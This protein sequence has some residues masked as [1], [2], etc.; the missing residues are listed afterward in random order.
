MHNEV[1][2][3][4]FVLYDVHSVWIFINIHV[5]RLFILQLTSS[6]LLSRKLLVCYRRTVWFSAYYPKGRKQNYL[7]SKL[8]WLFWSRSLHNMKIGFL[9]SLPYT[10][11]LNHQNPARPVLSISWESKTLSD[12]SKW[13]KENW[14]WHFLACFQCSLLDN[15]ISI[16]EI[17]HS[18]LTWTWPEMLLRVH[19]SL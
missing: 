7:F 12:I 19:V 13:K 9:G 17:V 11:V 18:Q 14:S 1:L 6:I 3:S 15:L 4:N 2:P 8:L 10:S 16:L 5:I